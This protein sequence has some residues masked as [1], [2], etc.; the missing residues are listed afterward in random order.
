MSQAV[1][2][3]RVERMVNSARTA[4]RT[5]TVWSA[6]SFAIGAS[7]PAASWMGSMPS[8]TF[9]VG[10]KGRCIG[11]VTGRFPCRNSRY[12][13]NNRAQEDGR[14]WLS[15]GRVGPTRGLC[16]AQPWRQTLRFSKSGNPTIEALYRT[17]WVSPELSERKRQRLAEK[18]SRPLELVVV[19][20]LNRE[21]K[22]HRCGKTGDLLIMEDMPEL[23]RSR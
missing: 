23:R 18:A 9:L 1:G 10:Q 17:H 7:R 21:W 5:L 13:R 14:C 20:P 4:R 8:L 11:S 3:G 16:R 2:P 15:D 19:Q 22:C 6:F 12:N